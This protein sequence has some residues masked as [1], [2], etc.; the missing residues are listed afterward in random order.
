MNSDDAGPKPGS[1]LVGYEEIPSLFQEGAL[2]Y[3]PSRP[4]ENL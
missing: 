1:R 4:V 2:V 3:L